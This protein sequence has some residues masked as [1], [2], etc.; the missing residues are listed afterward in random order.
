[1]SGQASHYI[2]GMY[3]NTQ[4]PAK[5]VRLVASARYVDICIIMSAKLPPTVA[6]IVNACTGFQ[7]Y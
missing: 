2:R 6:I 5:P 7:N 3:A 1:M 4:E